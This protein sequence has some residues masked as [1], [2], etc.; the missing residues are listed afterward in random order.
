M[1]FIDRAE[2][3]PRQ[4]VNFHQR[5]VISVTDIQGFEQVFGNAKHHIE[6]IR[7]GQGH[8]RLPGSNHLMITY[9]N[10]CRG[11]CKRGGERHLTQLF[12]GD[13]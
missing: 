3:A 5:A 9:L 1:L 13:F 11:A 10:A 2:F 6:Q 12:L 7:S 4:G 8:D